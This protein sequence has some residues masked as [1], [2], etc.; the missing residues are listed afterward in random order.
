MGDLLLAWRNVWRN[1]RRS[2]LTMLAIAFASGLLVFMLSF[3][4]GTYEDMINASVKTTTG[5]LQIMAK[6]YNEKKRIRMT[7]NDTAGLKDL[8]RKDMH[9]KAFTGRD[10]AFVLAQAG[11]RTG[12]VML[13]GINASSERSVSGINGRIIEG[14]YVGCCGRNNV[15]VGKLLADKL[16][17][18]IGTEITL[19]GQG[20]DGSVA[21]A[22]LTVIGIFD[23]GFEEYD[24]NVMMIDKDDFDRLFYMDGSVHRIVVMMDSY[25]NIAE[26][27]KKLADSGLMNGLEALSWD[28]LAPGLRQGI[29]LDLVSGFIMYGILV[30]V[31]AFS[32]LNTFIMAVFE[33]T[34]EF[35]VMLSLGTKPRRLVRVVMMESG[36]IGFIGLA[37]GIFAGSAVTLH[38]A[39]VGIFMQ[40]MELMEQYGLSGTLY[41]KLTLL[42]ASIG[43]CIVAFVTFLAALY[44]AVKVAGLKAAEAMKAV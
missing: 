23:T 25:R 21:A 16:K 15:I 19:L 22:L 7:V 35:G 27:K 10:E 5:H 38:Y 3:Q 34:H 6:G 11:N 43:P 8:L 39:R 40:G 26:L 44:P 42:S 36:F 32:I 31:A 29:E 9:V 13:M 33:R 20:R 41:P 28:E 2:L 18:K 30:I 14:G 12:G 37:L 1:T 24:R 4:F 17:L